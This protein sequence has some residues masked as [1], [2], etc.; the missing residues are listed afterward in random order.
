MLLESHRNEVG[1]GY[2]H[3][4]VPEHLG[5]LCLILS[6]KWQLTPV[7]LPGKFNGWRAWGGGGLCHKQSD[8]AEHTHAH[9]SC[10]L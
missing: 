2:I 1:N 5:C 6:R 7:L 4:S 9:L 10:L 8:T 3:S